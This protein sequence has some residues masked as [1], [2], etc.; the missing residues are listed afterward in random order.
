MHNCRCHIFHSMAFSFLKIIC[1]ADGKTLD[2]RYIVLLL[3]CKNDCIK[4][5]CGTI[6]WA[7]RSAVLENCFYS[8]EEKYVKLTF[9]LLGIWH[10]SMNSM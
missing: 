4:T 7:S 3:R 10:A 5:V 2:N 9:Y 6:F 8:N 1:V